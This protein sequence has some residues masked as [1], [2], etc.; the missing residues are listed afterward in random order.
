MKLLKKI[1]ALFVFAICMQTVLFNVQAEEKVKTVTEVYVNPLYQDVITE[2]DLKQPCTKK[3]SG[4]SQ[5]DLEEKEYLDEVE[6]CVQILREGMKQRKD[7]IDIYFK[8]ADENTGYSR[9]ILD[10]AFEH[11]GVST[12]G[13]YLLWHFEGIR[14]TMSYYSDGQYYYYEI[15]YYATYHTTLEQE[16]ALTA[17]INSVLK[18]LNVSKLSRQDKIKAVYDYI[19]KNVTYDYDNLNDDEYMLKYTAYAAMVNGIAVCQG[20]ALLLYRMSLDMGIDC[21]LISGIGA[22]GGHGWNIIKLGNV[23]YNADSTWDAG[24]SNYSYFLRSNATFDDHT[25]DDKYNTAEFNQQYPMASSDYVFTEEE[26]ITV[27][28]PVIQSVYSTVAFSV[29]VTWGA[30]ENADGYQLYRSENPD[31][32]FKCIK[33]I[34]NGQTEKYTNSGLMKGITYY[35]KVRAFK[36]N[37]QNERV[38][39]AFSKT[40]YMPSCV[41]FDNVY[42]NSTSR[43]RIL[44]NKVNGAEG[45]QIWRA[46]EENGTYKIVKS[47]T[48]GSVNTY[49]NTGLV[50]GHCYYYK[51]RAYTTVNGKKL[52]GA[53]SDFTAVTVLPEKTSVELTSTSAGK[54]KLKWT[55]ISGAAGYQIWRSSQMDGKYTLVKT[56]RD[57]AVISY[58]N[59]GLN[60]GEEYFY[61][62]RAYVTDGERSI[63]GAYSDIAGIR[64]AK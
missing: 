11:T 21:R 36:Y 24:R 40:A 8:A 12:E 61:K 54:I 25:R 15:R 45:Y 32:G 43:I 31:N 34:E 42:S 55:Q 49:S 1:F 59:S 20:Y 3:Q 56:I 29:K 62:V 19:C 23:Y 47:I 46:D 58:T 35:Y 26:I 52:F 64:C 41:V 5:I 60:A 9:V 53:Y 18:E 28:K 27:E 33:T 22:G 2:E 63:F 30:V 16:Q 39:S 4:I 44:W 14:T 50:S 37:K 13:D 10:K 51:M 6:A 17:K 48:D 38:F 7:T 57:G